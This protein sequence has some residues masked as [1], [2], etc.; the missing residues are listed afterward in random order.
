MCRQN[1]TINEK[2]LVGFI[3]NLKL[4]YLNTSYSV[5]VFP[6]LFV[7]ITIIQYLFPFKFFK[8]KLDLCS[9]NPDRTQKSSIVPLL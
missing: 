2:Y 7:S 8:Q 3:L 4:D 9:S 5:S 1:T 6:Q